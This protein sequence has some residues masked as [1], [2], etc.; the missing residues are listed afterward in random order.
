MS[1]SRAIP[2]AL[3]FRLYNKIRLP[4]SAPMKD[5]IAFDEEHGGNPFIKSVPACSPP[6]SGISGS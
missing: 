3:L 4:Y 2:D 6:L 5:I 1:T